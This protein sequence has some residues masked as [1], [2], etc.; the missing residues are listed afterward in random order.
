V[1]S[2]ADHTKAETGSRKFNSI[3]APE[4]SDETRKAVNAAFDAMSTWREETVNSSQKNGEKVIEKMAEAARS[5]GWPE[6]IVDATRTQMQ[7]ITRAQ[8]ETMDRMM[9]AWEEGVKSPMSNSP[10]GI[11]SKLKPLPN[12]SPIGSWPDGAALQAAATNPMQF[13]MQMTE[14]WRKG[15][16]DAMAFWMKAGAPFE[17]AGPRRSSSR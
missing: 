3:S 10:T 16:T 7:S 8:I 9:D 14:Q 6:Q 4:L 1:Q 11:L 5:L 17:G 12:M 2:K 13:W 15:W